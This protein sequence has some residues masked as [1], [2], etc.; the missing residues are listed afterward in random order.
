[1]RYH[2]LQFSGPTA[3]E[4][5]LCFLDAVRMA[6]AY[7]GKTS[8]VRL[9]LWDTFEEQHSGSFE[10]GI[11]REDAIAFYEYLQSVD[12]PFDYD[13]P[14]RNC[15]KD[16]IPDIECFEKFVR[17][18]PLGVYVTCAGDDILQHCFVIEVCLQPRSTFSTD[19]MER[20]LRLTPRRSSWIMSDRQYPLHA[21]DGSRPASDITSW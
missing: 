17:T 10:Y 4:S 8:L 5:S 14:F 2:K 7:L 20:K 16:S 9:E 21:F 6:L 1:M 12:I 15:P 3:S 13:L 18:L 19:M 11:R